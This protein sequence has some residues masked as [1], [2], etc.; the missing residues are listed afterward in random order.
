MK[1]DMKTK[2]EFSI[3]NLNFQCQILERNIL[4]EFILKL[5]VSTG[6]NKSGQVYSEG[7]GRGRVVPLL[8]LTEHKAM[9]THGG[10]EI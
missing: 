3:R 4:N 9:K 1:Q 8:I 5:T 6:N 10:A 7:V 2:F